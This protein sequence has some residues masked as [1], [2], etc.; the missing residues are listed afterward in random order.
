MNLTEYSTYFSLG[1]PGWKSW[2]YFSLQSQS[3]LLLDTEFCQQDTLRYGFF[4]DFRLSDTF[5]AHCTYIKPCSEIPQQQHLLK[6][7]KASAGAYALLDTKASQSPRNQDSVVLVSSGLL[8]PQTPGPCS[9]KC[10]PLLQEICIEYV[11]LYQHLS[12]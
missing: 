2:L 9:G 7:P 6:V 4:P 5:E 8:I 10:A 3:L 1:K 12:K 11:L